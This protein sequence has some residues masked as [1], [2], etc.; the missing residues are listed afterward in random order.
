MPGAAIT[1]TDNGSEQIAP[2]CAS[3]PGG[4]PRVYVGLQRP[5]AAVR[6][7]VRPFI[8]S[9]LPQSAGDTLLSTDP[10]GSLPFLPSPTPGLCPTPQPE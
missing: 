5:E 3:S 9:E 6:S 1:M 2:C 10:S 7:F 8:H 4:P